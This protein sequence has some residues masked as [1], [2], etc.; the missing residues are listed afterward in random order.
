MNTNMHAHADIRIHIDYENI[1]IKEMTNSLLTP[2]EMMSITSW[3]LSGL[4]RSYTIVGS[5]LIR[6]DM[7]VTARETTRTLVYSK[8]KSELMLYTLK[9]SAFRTDANICFFYLCFSIYQFLYRL[10]IVEI[11]NSYLN[12]CLKAIKSCPKSAISFVESRRMRSQSCVDAE[13]QTRW[14]LMI[15]RRSS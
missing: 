2:L 10:R 13:K 4:M 9:E 6:S 7:H 15:M 8:E 11:F 14:R 1:Y 5:M 3:G 12:E